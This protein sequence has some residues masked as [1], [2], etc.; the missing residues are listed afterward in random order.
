M[1]ARLPVLVAAMALTL[2]MAASSARA[3]DMPN[4]PFTSRPLV[5]P[6]GQGEASVDLMV[7]LDKGEPGEVFGVGSGLVW[8]RYSGLHV[9][10]SPLE[11]FEVGVALQFLYTMHDSDDR[12]LTAPGRFSYVGGWPQTLGSGSSHLGPFYFYGKY[13]FLKQLALEVGI[14]VPTDQMQGLN[15]PAIRIGVPFK[16]EL[17]PGLLA[18]HARGDAV[19]GFAKPGTPEQRAGQPAPD[20]TVV[21]SLFFDGG[22]TLNLA[23]FFG[24]VS[25]GFG[26]DV[27]STYPRSFPLSI[28]VGYTFI[29]ELDVYAG[30]TLANMLPKVGGAADAR[31]LTVGFNVRF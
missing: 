1:S 25:V 26:G 5:H 10:G 28:T 3:G 2:G 7:G 31:N 30:F 21:V 17:S 24:D 23:D 29:P 15:R 4:V 18:I 13:G 9:S 12:A 11:N 27:T 6:K 16:Y 22:I 14:V 8:D 19:I 20:S